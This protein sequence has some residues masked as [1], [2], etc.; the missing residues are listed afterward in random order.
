MKNS[1]NGLYFGTAGIPNSSP[2]LDTFS[3]IKKLKE[4]NLDVMEL[5]FVHGVKISTTT[6][7]KINTFSKQYNIFLSVHAPYYI[8]LNSLDPEKIEA[9]INRIVKTCEIASYCA[10]KDIVIH[11]GY[12]HNMDKLTA[13]NNIKNNLKKVLELISDYDV[14]LRIETMGK[15]S[16]F[17][18][19][20]EV[21]NLS[22]DLGPKVL[23]CLDFAHMYARSLGK[24]NSYNDFY[25]IFDDV[26]HKL[27]KD[28]LNNI[29][30]HISGIKYSDKGEVHHLN[31]KESQFNY[32]DFVKVLKDL[33]I[34][35]LIITESPN[36]EEDATLLKNLYYSNISL[37]NIP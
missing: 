30:I 34:K 11:P 10:A 6:A 26:K 13:Y 37:S 15:I 35:G 12:Y 36:L 14:I 2:K 9:S 27:G 29:H 5:E 24:I 33:N 23:P 8:N 28:A 20:E 1:K 32:V 21:L 25:K 3:G 7:N 31:L 16:Q 18:T 4:L 22:Q 19:L 17:G